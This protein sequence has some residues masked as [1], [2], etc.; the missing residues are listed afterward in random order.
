MSDIDKII[1]YHKRR[2]HAGDYAHSGMPNGVKTEH[3]EFAEALTSLQ[4]KVDWLEATYS[5][6]A[7]AFDREHE[8][9]KDYVKELN[10]KID[11]LKAERDGAYEKAAKVCDKAATEWPGC[12]GIAIGLTSKEIRKL[13]DGA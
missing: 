2:G 13:K 9:H 3:D 12:S 1:G 10:E 11:R 7:E 8:F 4:E 6:A 5:K